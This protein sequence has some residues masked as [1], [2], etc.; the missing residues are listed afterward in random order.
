MN[1]EDMAQLQLEATEIDLHQV[2]KDKIFDLVCTIN[3]LPG[4]R[5]KA[6]MITKCD[7]LRHWNEDARLA[8]HYAEGGI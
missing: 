8:K 3:V 4:G 1:H 7:E 2:I 6:I 5:E